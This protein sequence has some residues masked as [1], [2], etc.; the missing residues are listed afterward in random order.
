MQDM[1]SCIDSCLRCHSVCL[2]E[3]TQRCLA[4]RGKHI[5][6]R[7]AVLMLDCAEICQTAANFML[8]GSG[9]HK[10]TC[11]VCA[12]VCDAC[13]QSCEQVG[14]MDECARICRECAESC[15]R[16]AA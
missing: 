8:R 15:R 5:E 4:M 13:A 3:L 1:Q 9:Q 2:R 16:M 14:G 6:Q 11:R 10:L 12:E 7:H